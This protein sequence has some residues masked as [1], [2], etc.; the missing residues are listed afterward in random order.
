ALCACCE[1]RG[2]GGHQASEARSR[3]VRASSSASSG[4]A[5]SWASGRRGRVWWRQPVTWAG[6]CSTRRLRCRPGAGTSAS[7]APQSQTPRRRS[8]PTNTAP[9]RP[10]ASTP[11]SNSS[12]GFAPPGFGWG[13]DGAAGAVD[14][15]GDGDGDGAADADGDAAGVASAGGPACEPAG[16]LTAGGFAGSAPGEVLG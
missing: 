7:R 3:L 16:G 1:A 15:E 14:G 13:A 4:S 2:P 8:Q 5:C 9:P 12:T 11:P 10:V 6:W